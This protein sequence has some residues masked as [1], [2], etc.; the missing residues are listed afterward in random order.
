MIKIYADIHK[1]EKHTYIEDVISSHDLSRMKKEEL[2]TF[3]SNFIEKYG[4]LH[5]CYDR[6]INVIGSKIHSFGKRWYGQEFIVYITK[7]GPCGKETKQ[8][9][10]H[11]Y[12]SRGYLLNWTL[13]YFY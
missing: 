8:K 11:K 13:G 2:K 5:T 9:S 10:K 12:D 7:I 4:E 3:I 6:F 1:D